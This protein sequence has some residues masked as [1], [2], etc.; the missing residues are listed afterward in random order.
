[1]RLHGVAFQKLVF[2]TEIDP[3]GAG[4]EIVYLI[5]LGRGGLRWRVS[6]NTV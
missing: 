3:G 6:V 1:M 2:F 5:Q 4:C